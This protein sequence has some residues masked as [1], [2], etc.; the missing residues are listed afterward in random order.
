MSIHLKTL[1]GQ[2]I[3]KQTSKYSHTKTAQTNYSKSNTVQTKY[4][5]LK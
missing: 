2:Y 1:Y 4:R 5:V 3:T